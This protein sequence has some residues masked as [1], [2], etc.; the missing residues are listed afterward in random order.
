MGLVE[1]MIFEKDVKDRER[2]VH[3]HVSGEC[4]Q[5]RGAP[6]QMQ[7]GRREVCVQG[8]AR[9]QVWLEE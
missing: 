2:N 9:R 1:E 7:E 3:K 8:R 6:V 5:G 4:S